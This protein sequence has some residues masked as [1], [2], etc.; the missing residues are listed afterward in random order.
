GPNRRDR[1]P[2]RAL[3]R[4]PRVYGEGSEEYF[5]FASIELLSCLV[6]VVGHE[7]A[8]SLLIVNKACNRDP[9][10][11]KRVPPFLGGFIKIA[12]ESEATLPSKPGCVLSRSG[13]LLMVAPAPTQFYTD[14][15]QHGAGRPPCP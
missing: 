3:R 6:V 5:L 10:F 14:R 8:S 15:R 9:L 4:S 11:P 12:I 13:A 1:V 7:T 2:A